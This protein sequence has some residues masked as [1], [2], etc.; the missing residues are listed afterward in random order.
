MSSKLLRYPG[1]PSEHFKSQ[2]CFAAF[3][4][5]HGPDCRHHSCK[6]V[7]CV[8]LSFR[9]RIVTLTPKTF[10]SV[11]ER[12]GLGLNLDYV[13]RSISSIVDEREVDITTGVWKSHQHEF[14]S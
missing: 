13:T 7:E 8:T 1:A 2:Q 3:W 14:R 6:R 11:R 5:A 12:R 9:H 4:N 10:R